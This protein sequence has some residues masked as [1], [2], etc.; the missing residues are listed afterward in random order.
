M[1]VLE[2][3]LRHAERRRRGEQVHQHGRRG[4]D[5][6]A[7]DEQQQR[8]A[9]RDHQAVDERKPAGEGALEIVAPRRPRRRRA[10]HPAAVIARGRRARCSAGDGTH[11]R[12]HEAAAPLGRRRG[13]HAG[14]V[15]ERGEHAPGLARRRHDLQLGGRPGSEGV[16]KPLVAGAR[17]RVG[18]QDAGRRHR[19][20]Q[21]EHRQG[22]RDEHGERQPA[23]HERAA[24]D[25]PSPARE[26]LAAVLHGAR[27]GQRE[28][29]DA[30]AEARQQRRQ[31]GQRRSEHEPHG[32]QDPER[33]RAERLARHEHDRGQRR[34]HGHAADEHRLA[35]A[36]HR[37]GD[38]VNRAQARS[39]RGAEANHDEERV[40]DPHRERE[41]Q[42]EVHRPDRDA[43]EL[44]ADPERAGGGDQP[45]DREQ[46]RDPGRGE[47]AE[48]DGEHGQRDRP[49]D[50]LGAQHRGLVL[51]VELRPQ[52]RGAGERHLDSRSRGRL[53]RD[54]GGDSRR[55][56]SR[57]CRRP[58]RRARRPL[59]RSA[60]STRR[61]G[62]PHR[63]DRGVAPQQRPPRGR[64]SRGRPGSR[65]RASAS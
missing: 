4:G 16:L 58:R 44:R 32:E 23:D 47:R 55:A 59:A 46:Q 18:G 3:Q 30:R 64:S 27:P 11:S 37:L 43:G 8:E 39:Q 51:L 13:R 34:Q 42:R 9:H 35:G 24:P 53:E 49:G 10:R 50:H 29:V 2:D 19:R 5:R 6:C 56:P 7:D 20:A 62:R 12:Q 31:Q 57:P 61:P 40:V 21:A 1:A 54:R 41:H 48:G 45:Q 38:G 36:V 26:R 25:Q 60:R 33:A 65:C 14:A 15:L 52:A 28:A 17:A 22:E 63:S